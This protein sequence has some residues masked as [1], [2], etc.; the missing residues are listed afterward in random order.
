LAKIACQTNW[1]K[2]KRRIEVRRKKAV[3][4][5]DFALS[6]LAVFRFGV[7]VNCVDACAVRTDD[8][9]WRS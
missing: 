5:V 6:S 4:E 8:E 1:C 2:S 7:D 3:S 9:V